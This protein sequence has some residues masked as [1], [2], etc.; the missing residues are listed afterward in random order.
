MG[1]VRVIC[2]QA[3]LYHCDSA[4]SHVEVNII[5]LCRPVHHRKNH[6]QFLST[7]HPVDIPGE[8]SSSPKVIFCNF[9]S[10]KIVTVITVPSFAFK[11]AW[12][13][14]SFKQQLLLY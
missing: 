7:A 9:V 5:K 10:F 8:F 13:N 14:V 11:I 3:A 1:S 12:D 2:L 4:A 6:L